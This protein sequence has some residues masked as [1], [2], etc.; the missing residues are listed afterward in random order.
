MDE[1]QKNIFDK[2]QAALLSIP[3][4]A[5]YYRDR[6]LDAQERFK[7]RE[8]EAPWSD[9]DRE[10]MYGFQT[11]PHLP[12][13]E[14]VRVYGELLSSDWVPP[15]NEIAPLSEKRAP[16]SVRATAGLAKLPVRN[17]PFNDSLTPGN[18]ADA[19]ASWQLWHEQIKSGK[20]TF[21]FEGDPTEYDLNGPASKQ[22]LERIAL[23]HKRDAERAAGWNK[24][25][26]SSTAAIV[27]NVK[28]PPKAISI[29]IIIASAILLTS[30]AWYF[31]K[32][33]KH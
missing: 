10:S 4:H 17:K 28:N 23:D 11:L 14:T 8:G 19:H 1:Q 13:P 21:R 26:P 22:K 7:K 29:S 15:G 31:V 25:G 20:R 3:G 33:R 2:A 27:N 24:L 5:E 6:I 18:I 9:Y 30:L 16:L 12:S 32:T